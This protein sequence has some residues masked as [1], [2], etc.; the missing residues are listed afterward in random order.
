MFEHVIRTPF[1]MKPVFKPCERPTLKAN[2]TDIFIHAKKIIELDI[3]AK[4]IYF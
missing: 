1:D 2:L 4:N 3:L